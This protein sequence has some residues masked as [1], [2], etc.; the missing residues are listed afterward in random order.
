[1]PFTATDDLTAA[2]EG[3]PWP[4]FADLLAATSL[5]FLILFAAIAVP[6]LKRAGEAEARRNTL[7]QI[8]HTLRASQ[9]T[10]KVH[11]Q[12]VGDY[13]LVE[14]A[15]EATFPKD[16]YQLAHM[17]REGKE[18]LHG[19]VRSLVRDSLM[20]LIDQ[21][22]VVGHASAEGGDERNWILSSARAAT[23]SLF[24]I[25]SVRV[26]ACQ[27]SAM[28]RSHYY[29]VNPEQARRGVVNERDRRIELEV[30]PIIPSD[31]VQ[32]ARRARCVDPRERR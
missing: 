9:D 31:T 8:E 23:I 2:A 27:V 32:R 4:A 7:R 24:L 6:A 15:G 25:D 10:T 22:Q 30:R 12:Q 21:I 5:L 26:P 18:I 13:L 29:P 28:G 20:R 19:F 16:D 1:M 3:G 11:I 17:K 14:I